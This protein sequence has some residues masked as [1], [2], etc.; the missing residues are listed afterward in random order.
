MKTTDNESTDLALLRRL[1][2]AYGAEPARWPTGERDAALA[3]LQR[4]AEARAWQADA[5]QFD[6]LLHT[7]PLPAVDDALRAAVLGAIPKRTQPRD[8][9]RSESFVRRIAREIEDMLGGWRLASAAMGLSAVFG[10]LLALNAQSL[11]G[12]EPDLLDLAQV[13]AID[14][15]Y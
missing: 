3:L 9:A 5:A 7:S 6:A 15:E 12:A 4:S 8:T 1:L 2:D 10:V 13:Q 14:L 11:T